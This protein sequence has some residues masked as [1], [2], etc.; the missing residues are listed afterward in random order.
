MNETVDTD[1]SGRIRKITR[2]YQT[3]I[4]PL[5]HETVPLPSCAGAAFVGAHR[6]G[7]LLGQAI[8]LSEAQDQIAGPDRR[9]PL[10]ELAFSMLL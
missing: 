9:W 8:E 6:F 3:P 1:E 7:S 10:R 2:H 4:E 5:P